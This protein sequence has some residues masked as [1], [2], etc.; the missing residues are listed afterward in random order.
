[1]G[2]PHDGG[3][4]HARCREI[5]RVLPGARHDGH[6]VDVGHRGPEYP[7]RGWRGERVAALR[8]YRANR[9]GRLP[10]DGHRLRRRQ[11][12][13]RAAVVRA[14]RR[15]AHDELHPFDRHPELFGEGLRQQRARALPH[16]HLAGERAVRAVVGHLHAH[17][18]V[19]ALRPHRDEEEE[20]AAECLE[21]RAPI[22]C[23]AVEQID[24]LVAL[25]LEVLFETL[26][27]ASSEV[28]SHGAAPSRS[29]RP[30]H[31]PRRRCAGRCRSGR[32]ACRARG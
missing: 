3:V 21:E 4:Q 17:G 24:D 14:Q 20:A 31:A 5:R 19:R 28:V 25:G 15:I 30:R 22:G 9:S 7:P 26:L 27:V 8:A 2:T 23:Q 11:A 13:P 32:D 1:M 16:L 12:R 6:A 10:D 18:H 29:P